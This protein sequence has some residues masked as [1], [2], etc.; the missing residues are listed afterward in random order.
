MMILPVL[1]GCGGLWLA[2]AFFPVHAIDEYRLWREGVRAGG[3]VLQVE[4]TDETD[5]DTPI[6]SYKFSYKPKGEVQ[7]RTGT[8]YTT[9]HEWK[10][11]DGVV[12]RYWPV[13]PEVARP[14]EARLDQ[15]GLAGALALLFP[16]T[17]FGVPYLI[18]KSRRKTE[19]LLIGGL[20][21]EVEVISVG[22]T[23]QKVNY[24]SEYEIILRAPPGVAGDRIYLKR[25]AKA[26]INF[27]MQ[28]VLKKVPVDIIYDPSE[29]EELIF[30][31]ALI[32][33]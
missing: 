2:V 31:A 23:G 5:D 1:F 16:V 20:A 33:V 11:G 28:Y 6:F 8:A 25:T 24:E 15:S 9:G 4:R 22:L 10:P 29:P 32:D 17:G 19:R 12:V 13:R 26:E 18:L 30:P 21:A 7:P 14:L 27:L 3:V